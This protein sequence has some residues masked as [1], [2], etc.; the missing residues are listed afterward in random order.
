MVLDILRKRNKSRLARD[1]LILRGNGSHH[2]E[3]ADS[4]AT[5]GVYNSIP[6]SLRNSPLESSWRFL[7]NPAFLFPHYLIL[8]LAASGYSLNFSIGSIAKNSCGEA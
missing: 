6:V 5:K 3:I 4:C 2:Y 7:K 1:S 8:T